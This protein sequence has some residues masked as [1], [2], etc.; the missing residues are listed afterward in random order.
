MSDISIGMLRKTSSFVRTVASV[1]LISF[2]TVTLSPG[3]QAIAQTISNVNSAANTAA[4]VTLEEKSNF[5]KALGKAKQ[6]LRVLADHPD[7]LSRKPTTS[8]R[9]AN[10]EALRSWREELR[11]L[12]TETRTDFDQVAALLNTKNLPA[13]IKQ[14]HADALARYQSEMAALNQDLDGALTATD[15]AM[16]KSKAEAAY[17]RLNKTKLG[18]AQQPFD[19]NNLPN[20]SLKPD[21]NRKP[22][23]ST[24]EFQA[25]GLY[26]NGVNGL[27]Q[28]GVYDYSKLTGA[29]DPAF[30]QATT[31]VTLS[32]DIQAKATALHY[33]PVEIYNWVRNNVQWQ[34][35]WG[36]IQDASHTLSAQRGNAMDIA[37]LTIALFRASGIPAR[38]VHGT[39]DVPEDKFRN[40]VGG[41]TNLDAAADFASA[42][43]IPITYITA[44]GKIS[45]LRMEHVWVEA[46]IDFMPSR[47]AIN[48]SADSWIAMDPSYKQLQILPGIDIVQISGINLTQLSN[49]FL[50]SGTLNE[51]ESWATGYNSDVL[52]TAQAQT[53][54]AL[55]NYISTKPNA[56]VSDV[57]GGRKI[58]EQIVP[59]LPASL[60]NKL[61][62][63]G[64]KYATLPTALE[65]QITFAFGRDI[66]G[67]LI[68]PKTFPWAK[69]NNQQVT[70]S[71]KPAT[72]AD[73]DT[74]KALLPTG[75]IT[76]ISQ[77]PGAIPAYLIN[78]IPELKMNGQ[79]IMSGNSM[80]LGTDLDFVFNPKFVSSGEQPFHYLLPAGSYLAVAV[81]AGS[82]SPA[83]LTATR[84]QLQAT[85]VILESNNQAQI[86]SLTREQLLGDM[87]QAGVLSYYAQY[88]AFGYITGL[89]QGGHHQLSAGVGSFG[90]EPNVDMFFGIPRRLT[91]G[92]AAMNIPIV[93]A[94]TQDGTDAAA[95]RNYNTQLGVL[96]STLEHAV[97]E[98]MFTSPTNPGEAISAVK[99]LQ[100]ATQ[101][102][103]RIYQIT[104]AN[105]ETVLPNIHHD[106]GTMD[107]IRSALAVG[108]TVIT[109]SSP[110]SVPGW[111][112]AG[113]VILDADTGAGAWKI[114]GGQNGGFTTLTGLAVGLIGGIA[115]I[116]A[117]PAVAATVGAATVLISIINFLTLSQEQAL[118]FN[119]SRLLGVISGL[120][121]AVI[122][123]Q[124][125]LFTLTPVF[126]L[127]FV[128]LAILTLRLL[129][130]E[131]YTDLYTFD[132]KFSRER[133]G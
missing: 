18:R 89:E 90:Y 8:E 100:K 17:Q 80:T 133:Y 51:T 54:A 116:V 114:N 62:F 43:G 31:E 84:A 85:K 109:H 122:L 118:D 13:V 102:G 32:S 16:V 70:L 6:Q 71:F 82:V 115:A 117:S 111:S 107:E 123:G 7:V 10:K 112:G 95:K 36:A 35:T 30:L 69:L 52:Q 130:L 65:Q 97:P 19:P 105:Q 77:L 63:T 42:G 83:L 56:T 68:N 101:Q 58:V 119:M 37:S 98:Q 38:Y 22:K 94:T 59:T 25:A 15:D 61:V 124:Y 47:G 87:F 92:G 104:Q 49:N 20:R 53:R 103:Q 28:V 46:A 132:A 76:N 86:G 41:F 27:A 34:P 74:L 21:R 99:A 121:L 113:Y 40:W 78:V 1:V 110:V 93:N 12:D 33:N 45:K 108:K 5:G 9:K 2:S 81:V 64:A 55:Q 66:E 29:N 67:E 26:S 128:L 57:I 3:A 79:V 75:A 126:I 48:K 131:I 24:A 72:Q 127:G 4:Q 11:R 73:E 106:S 120:T 129:I 96:S 60:P 23:T 39:I 50:A 88:T 44:G 91:T 14:R 125:V